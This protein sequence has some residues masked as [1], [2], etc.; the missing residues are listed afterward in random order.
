MDK[1]KNQ[2]NPIDHDRNNQLVESR[3]PARVTRREFVQY[4]TFAL[5]GAALSLPLIGCGGGG[6]GGSGSGGGDEPDTL[7]LDKTNIEPGQILGI[8][9]SDSPDSDEIPEDIFSVGVEVDE[10]VV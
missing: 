4:S 9:C 5:V 2:N 10:T 3:R 7:T 6:G 8:Q 1:R